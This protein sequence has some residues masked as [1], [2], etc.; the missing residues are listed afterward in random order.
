MKTARTLFILAALAALCLGDATAAKT[1]PPRPQQTA[2][3]QEQQQQARKFKIYCVE[4]TVRVESM[5]EDELREVC[6]GPICDLARTEFVSLS[7]A[8]KA[9]KRFGGVGAPCR[10]VSETP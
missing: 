9:A 2:G 8:R 5:T 6:K 3:T 7:V 10:C 4:G 1:T